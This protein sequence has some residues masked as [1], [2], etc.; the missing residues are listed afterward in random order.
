MIPIFGIVA[1]IGKWGPV[2]VKAYHAG[3]AVAKALSEGRD[4]L[5]DDEWSE[6]V[7]EGDEIDE[8]FKHLVGREEEE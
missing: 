5:T 4:E 1:A 3:L 7:K 2:A 6:L 8:E